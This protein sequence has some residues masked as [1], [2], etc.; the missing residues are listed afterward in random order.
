MNLLKQFTPFWL[1]GICIAYFLVGYFSNFYTS[2]Y[3]FILLCLVFQV[4]SGSL[5]H[6]LLVDA[7][8]NIKFN[9]RERWTTWLFFG[10]TAAMAIK[11][12]SIVW[13]FPDLFDRRILFMDGSRLGI[14]LF[15]LMPSFLGSI[16]IARR[17]DRS[18]YRDRLQKAP[19]WIFIQRNL[20]GI[21][22]SIFFLFIYLLFA[23]TINFPGYDT[24]DRYFDTDISEWLS[25]LAYVTPEQFM[26]RAV[27]PAVLLFLRPLVEFISFF[28]H[29]D[30]FQAVFLLNAL[31][32]A[33]CVF[34]AWLITRHITENTTFSLIMAF[35]LGMG[36]PHLL[37][38]SMIETYIY[39]AF[40]LLLFVYLMQSNK[41]DLKY[42]IPAGVLV[43][44]I[45]V[46]NLIQTCILYVFKAPRVK[47]IVKYVAAVLAITLIL[48]VLQA[49]IYQYVKVLYNPADLLFEQK[50]GLNFL[51]KDWARVGRFLLMVRAILLYAV[52][53]PKPFILT[54][55]IGSATPTFSVFKVTIGEFHVAGYTGLADLTAKLWMVIFFA[56]CILFVW[57]LFKSPGKMRLPLALV[58]C[59][60][61]NLLLHTFW[62]D[63]PM[64]YSPDW[65]YAL[66]LF[67]AYSFQDWVNNKWVQVAF[68][69]FLGLMTITNLD[70]IHQIMQV[71]QPFFG[72]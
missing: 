56:A 1:T 20:A 6:I 72:K 66:V 61:F 60:G 31:T 36:T 69:L 22:L 67:V 64:L 52:V 45:T 5:S 27:H 28:L 30:K 37:L 14:F 48:N 57:K 33:S 41:T 7:Q 51:D 39:S 2:L 49:Q 11:A 25:R 71:S 10:L 46:T 21:V 40:A 35:L 63:D 13:Q 53:A 18:N 58:V 38:G 4:I 8:S 9:W 47:V 55:E 15:L 43:F 26:A 70:L 19:V 17:L 44:G 59:M 32:G 42:T 68:I 3:S 29:G 12:V 65:A 16:F 50:Y 23:N 54:T 62:G 24:V 34:L